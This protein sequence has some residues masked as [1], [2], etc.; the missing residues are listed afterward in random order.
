M[1]D[2]GGIKGIIESGRFPGVYGLK[3]GPNMKVG[4]SRF[5]KRFDRVDVLGEAEF[6]YEAMEP[7][8][9][10]QDKKFAQARLKSL[11]EKD[12]RGELK[13]TDYQ[14]EGHPVQRDDYGGGVE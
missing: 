8:M 6:E 4:T 9:T 12:A 3:K 5:E 1:G 11:R 14:V 7:T 2:H 13:I 10:E